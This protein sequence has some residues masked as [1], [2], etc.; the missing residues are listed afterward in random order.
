MRMVKA[1]FWIEMVALV[2]VLACAVALSLA[3]PGAAGAAKAEPEP[4]IPPHASAA[5]A[6]AYEGI[7]TDTHCGAKHSAGVG[8]AAADC[9]RACVHSGESFALVDGDNTYSLEGEPAALK[10][11]AGQRVRIMGTLTGKT[12]SVAA[13]GAS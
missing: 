6:Q 1:R 9:T 7:V 8:M 3:T 2:T 12:I 5:T 11:V 4:G 10:R 13:I